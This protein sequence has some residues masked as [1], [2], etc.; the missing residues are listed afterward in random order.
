MTAIL[1]DLLACVQRYIDRWGSALQIINLHII[2]Q[3]TYYQGAYSYQFIDVHV[4][5]CVNPT[6]SSIFI[7]AAS[8]R[9]HRVLFGLLPSYMTAILQDLLACVQ[10]FIDRW[11]SRGLES[12]P[13]GNQFELM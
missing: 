3:S 12:V 11:S 6:N 9:A 5:N 10:R 13:R 8:G 2:H 7:L 4:I 1:Q